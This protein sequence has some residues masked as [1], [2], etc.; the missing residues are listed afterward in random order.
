MVDREE[1]I[2]RAESA[3]GRNLREP[4]NVA[5]LDAVTASLHSIIQ[6]V[7]GPGS[8]KTSV[9]VLR[10]LYLLLVEDIRPDQILITTFTR[11]AARELRSRWLDWGSRIC[12]LLS[13]SHDLSHI[14][15]NRCSIDTLDS[16]IHSVLSDYRE[17][18][19]SPPDVLD[20]TASRLI[21]KRNHFTDLYQANKS[22]LNTLLGRYTFDRRPPPNQATA[23]KEAKTLLERL[24]QDRVNLE[25]Y[26][27]ADVSSEI[28][29]SVL[30]T[31][32][33]EARETNTFNHALLQD[34]FLE[35]L[36]SDALVPWTD[37]LQVLLI[38]EYQDT[39]PLQEAIYFGIINASRSSVMIVGDDDQ[40][41]YRFRGGSVELFTDFEERCE[42]ATGRAVVRRDMV[43]NYRSRPE[44]VTFVNQHVSV[45][46]AFQLARVQPPKPP[47]G[48][49]RVSGGTPVLGMFRPD[50]EVL[51]DDLA[52]FL[53][54]LVTERS[55][56][57]G[58]SGLNVSLPEAGDLGDMV[59][60]GHSV[61]EESYD[62]YNSGTIPR[63]PG[64]L[65][66][67]MDDR[68]MSIFNPRGRPLRTIDS[69]QLLL[70]LLLHAVDKD[71]QILDSMIDRNQ[72]TLESQYFLRQW[73]G[74]AMQLL[75][76]ADTS[77]T[78]A[79]IRKF[80]DDW[81]AVS[82]GAVAEGSLSEMPTL[83][84][85]FTLMKFVPGF[86]NDP[87]HQVWLEAI[88]RVVAGSSQAS[89]YGM[90]LLQNVSRRDSSRHVLRSRQSLIRDALV[91]IAEDEIDVDEDIMPSVPR[92]RL[93][94]MTIHQAKGLEFP[95]VIVD[96][97]T[98]F[99][100]N[101]HTQRFR[102]FPARESN[103]V[104]AE[105]DLEPHL[106]EPLRGHR[107]GIDRTFDDLMRLFYVA[108]SRAQCA[109]LL[110]GHENQLRYR[111][112]IMNVA[113]GWARNE[114]WAWK[115]AHQ[116]GKPPVLIDPPFLEI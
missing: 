49:V 30:E 63:F 73:R 97:G 99:K 75:T 87:E 32:R 20:E 71:G 78:G 57:L 67:S 17:T 115:Q 26:R 92:D 66:Q 69:V 34:H 91:P 12:S 18:G 104:V 54:S 114:T 42:R 113:L 3:L 4:E 27:A 36:H 59:L 105:N 16:T 55:V 22:V 21:L 98:R 116:D 108:Y 72:L 35:R 10:A 76:Q 25:S 29:V 82:A 6:L 111:T 81:G 33:R 39:N 85:I 14:D 1:F 90:R 106:S 15:L 41:M 107:P 58:S 2:H 9:L 80:I 37:R 44:I 89:P 40:A 64:V 50:E 84:L 65:R 112:T 86:Q 11:R 62:R 46:D 101:H 110:I 77:P 103:V 53:A 28:I 38:D 83:E 79:G 31:Y 19:S 5:Q 68:G 56:S 8:G 88:T 43:R 94:V 47:I 70:G 61:S 13:S 74:G 7:A 95:L 52:D 93:Q 109:L 23:L 51:A 45:D 96:V 100:T 60:L 48:A 24:I 102:R